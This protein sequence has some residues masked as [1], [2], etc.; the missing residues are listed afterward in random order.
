M[1]SKISKSIAVRLEKRSVIENS[2]IELY[3]YGLFVLLSNIFFFFIS[4]IC[5]AI[6]RTTMESILFYIT[7]S[8]LRRYAGGIHATSENICFVSTTISM[9]IC[10]GLIKLF[11]FF[12]VKQI[13][14]FVM[15][16]AAAFIAVLSPLDSANKP[17]TSEEKKHYKKITLGILIL[18]ILISMIMYLLNKTNILYSCSISIVLESILLIIGKIKR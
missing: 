4:I 7:F 12:E 11:I 6:Y 10:N 9:I 2:E 1:I 5:G 18:I 14:L 3:E 17:L 16:I 8:L 15:V 13:V